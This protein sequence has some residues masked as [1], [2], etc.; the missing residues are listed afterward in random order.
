MIGL[1]RTWRYK[2]D[3][4]CAPVLALL[5]GTLVGHETTRTPGSL[6]LSG[7]GAPLCPQQGAEVPQ[8]VRGGAASG[9]GDA[10]PAGEAGGVRRL[11]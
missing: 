5:V 2:S 8:A 3:I 4:W 1:A 6:R 7:P 9:A 11:R 10:L